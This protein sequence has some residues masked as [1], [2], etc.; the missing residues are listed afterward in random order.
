M[1]GM[2]IFAKNEQKDSGGFFL[3]HEFDNF[4][5]IEIKKAARIECTNIVEKRKSSY[6]L[7]NTK[8]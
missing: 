3:K 1:L 2:C 4:T 5:A 6:F 8:Y 7:V